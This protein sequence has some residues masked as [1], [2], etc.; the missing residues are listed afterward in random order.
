MALLANQYVIDR[1]EEG[2]TAHL[3]TADGH[4]LTIP[5]AWLPEGAR[6]GQVLE[7]SAAPATDNAS[8][9]VLVVNEIATRARRDE[10][11]E[12]RAGLR[13]GPEGDL[14]L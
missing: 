12:L 14:E 1:I 7:V 4:E 10:L 5:A 2:L 13:K 3:E 6:E 8:V 9:V 11:A